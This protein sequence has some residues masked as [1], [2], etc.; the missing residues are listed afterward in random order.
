MVRSEIGG[1][2]TIDFFDRSP[3][4]VAPELLG[5]QLSQGDV[6]LAI[7]EVE[8]YLGAEDPA[9]HAFVGRTPR[10]QAMSGP[11]GHGYIYLSYGMHLCFNV[12]CH[13]PDQPGAVLIRAGEV[14]AG[15]AI[16]VARRGRE[17]NLANGPGRL[18][19]ALGLERSWNGL[20]LTT[21]PVQLEPPVGPVHPIQ[22]AR[23]P[24]VGISKAIEAP[25]RFW[26]ST[27]TQVSKRSQR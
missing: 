6:S 13:R 25:L 26:L 21:G 2:R 7:V 22:I 1:Q 16:V 20:S 19:Q 23:G 17:D 12:V 27:S 10:N 8:A 3:E 11:T 4:V 15:R 9:S 5:W 24:R 18:G 14:T